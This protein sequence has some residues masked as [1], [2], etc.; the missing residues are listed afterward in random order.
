MEILK[1]GGIAAGQS[2]TEIWNGEIRKADQGPD[3]PLSD[4]EHDIENA[5]TLRRCFGESISSICASIDKR[6]AGKYTTE[7]EYVRDTVFAGM[8]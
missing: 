2:G 7:I 1:N 4:T 8:V 5:I 3:R 6:T